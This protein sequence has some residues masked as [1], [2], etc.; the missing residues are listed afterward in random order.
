MSYATFIA[1]LQQDFMLTSTQT[2]VSFLAQAY[3]ATYVGAYGVV[4][5]SKSGNNYDGFDVA[6]GL[7]LLGSGTAIQI[8]PAQWPNGTGDLVKQGSIAINGLSGP[9]KFDPTTGEAPG[10]IEWWSVTGTPPSLSYA[11]PPKII[12]AP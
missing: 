4:Y 8:G 9:L 3:D 10:P 11:S 7:G 6:T 12:P 2:Q 5:G 1:D